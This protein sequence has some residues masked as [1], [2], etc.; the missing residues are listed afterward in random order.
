M[1]VC[2]NIR[3]YK[4]HTYKFLYFNAKRKLAAKGRLQPFTLD[5]IRFLKYRKVYDIAILSLYFIAK[6][7]LC[8]QRMAK[9]FT[10]VKGD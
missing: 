9:P 4:F 1:D 2:A 6:R 8:R 3:I 10:L 5:F 7:M